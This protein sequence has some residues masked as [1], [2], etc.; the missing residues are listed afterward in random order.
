MNVLSQTMVD[1]SN[2]VRTCWAATNAPV[3]L[4]MSWQ[5]IKRA[6]KVGNVQIEAST[7]QVG[8]ATNSGNEQA[9]RQYSFP[10]HVHFFLSVPPSHP[11][12]LSTCSIEKFGVKDRR[13]PYSLPLWPRIPVQTRFCIG[14][15]RNVGT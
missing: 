12:K 4:V 11:C 8:T 1:V 2:T 5:L 7:Y 6:V 9:W 15:G 10:L 13:H 3:S 14:G